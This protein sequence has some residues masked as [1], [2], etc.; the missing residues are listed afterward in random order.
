[1]DSGCEMVNVKDNVKVIVTLRNECII[2]M[3]VLGVAFQNT[4]KKIKSNGSM[5]VG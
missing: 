5:K 4:Q 3:N 2:A 1:M